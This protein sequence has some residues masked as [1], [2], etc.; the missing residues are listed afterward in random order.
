MSYFSGP[1]G[2]TAGLTAGAALLA[3][4]AACGAGQ[5]QGAGGDAKPQVMAAFYPLQW[6]TER[7]GG[8]DVSV[9]PLTKPGVEPHDL[10]LTP[11][12]VVGLAEADLTVYIKGVQP[13]LDEAVEHNA[14]DKGFDAATVVPKLP[15]TGD[16]HEHEGE[17]GQAGHSAEH[18]EGEA[19]HAHEGEAVSYD[20]HLW[21]DPSRFAIVAN[22]LGDRLAAADP[23]RA[24]AHK[25][26]AAAVAAELTALDAEM[27]RGLGSCAG[28]ALV[29]SHAAFGYLAG[30]YGLE[31]VGISGIDPEAEPSLARLAEVEKVA[32]REK[33]TTI[34]TEAL[35]SP[36]VAEVLA[37]QVGA[38]T[39][40]LD[41]LESK[42]ASGDYLTAMRANLATL[43]TALNCT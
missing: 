33:V 42:P 19:A 20:P 11:R 36:K 15:A 3:A 38:K 13:A 34:F 23:A 41:P 2:R 32:K 4:T 1:W 30:R 14:K 17:A 29:T 24:K 10:E 16:A 35:V 12:Q 39:A 9:V 28:H 22:K 31:Q 8:G 40:V 26:R 7:V 25:D 5:A 27:K 18:E 43:R 6:L 37:K 21:L